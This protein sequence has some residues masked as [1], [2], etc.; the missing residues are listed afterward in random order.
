MDKIVLGAKLHDARRET[1][2]SSDRVA[3][4]CDCAPT[5]IRAIEGGARLPSVPMMVNMCNV[6][7][8]TPNYL[9]CHELTFPVEKSDFLDTGLT[10]KLFLRLQSLPKNKFKL[11]LGLVEDM[12]NRIQSY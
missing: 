2:L 12:L 11:A 5:T 7:K 9:L 8:V 6:L 10:E 4:L 1:K 3:D